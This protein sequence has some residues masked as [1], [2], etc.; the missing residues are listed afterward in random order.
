MYKKV[1]PALLVGLIAVPTIGAVRKDSFSS[2]AEAT[3][4]TQVEPSPSA[5]SAS[6]G[7]V[8][9]HESVITESTSTHHDRPSVLRTAAASAMSSA[10]ASADAVAPAAARSIPPAVT[11]ESDEPAATPEAPATEAPATETPA[12]VVDADTETPARPTSATGTAATDAPAGVVDADTVKPSST[13][14]SPTTVGPFNAVAIQVDAAD[15]HGLA[16]VTAN[17]YQGSTLVKSTSTRVDGK[18][19]ASHTATVNLPSGSYTIRYNASDNAGNVSTTKTMDIV[20]DA[21]APTATVKP[22]SV[23]ANGVYRNGQLQAH[24]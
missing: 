22:E 16:R 9:E 20:V 14:V 17:I 21:D 23:G 4:I 6:T 12:D 15:N 3:G 19:T 5:P 11:V 8:D 24:R 10:V 13:L 18:T 2:A 7:A 1:F